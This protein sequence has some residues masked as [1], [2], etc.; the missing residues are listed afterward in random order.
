VRKLTGTTR[1]ALRG[2]IAATLCLLAASAAHAG[3]SV[4]LWDLRYL[5]HATAWTGSFESLDVEAANPANIQGN[6]LGFVGTPE[7]QR[8]EV[9]FEVEVPRSV[10][11]DTPLIAAVQVRCIQRE[12]WEPASAIATARKSGAPRAVRSE[13]KPTGNLD[14][15]TIALPAGGPGTYRIS[16]RIGGTRY[17]AGEIGRTM[18][19][20]PQSPEPLSREDWFGARLVDE[21]ADR[22]SLAVQALGA[23][24]TLDADF[25]AISGDT[26]GNVVQWKAEALEPRHFGVQ[27]SVEVGQADVGKPFALGLLMRFPLGEGRAVVSDPLGQT[28]VEVPVYACTCSDPTRSDPGRLPAAA[29]RAVWIPVK[30]TQP[31]AH[32]VTFLD[33]G[34]GRADASIYRLCYLKAVT[35]E[36]PALLKP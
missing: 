11:A 22:G 21:I 20:T 36:S 12:G 17:F 27:Y 15:W 8:V 7:N 16:V 31:G 14:T 29:V 3:G 25:P 34:V 9:D 18:T 6:I 24:Q 4:P 10:P 2:T 19:L 30:F 5:G 28:L 32:V 33:E 23:R 35:D 13:Y 1:Y 26:V